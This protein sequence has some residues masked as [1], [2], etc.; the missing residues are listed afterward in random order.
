MSLYLE[1]PTVTCPFFE[2]V[3]REMRNGRSLTELSD[4]LSKLIAAVRAT[5]K[6]GKLTYALSVQPT[7]EPDGI[8][9]EL[10]DELSV[11]TPKLARGR[12]IFFATADNQLSR[13]D[14]RQFEMLL[15]QV[16]VAAPQPIIEIPLEH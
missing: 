10:L 4:E 8:T 13:R 16:P 1:T 7:D 14:P 12:S 2:T 5:R 6:A 15:E 3:L 11:K 9:I